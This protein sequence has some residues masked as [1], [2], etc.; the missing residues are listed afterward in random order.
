VTPCDTGTLVARAASIHARR[1][2]VAALVLL[3]AVPVFAQ[4][5][6]PNLEKPDNV[7]PSVLKDIGFDQNLGAQTPMDALF[8]DETGKDVA[9]G[10]LF[11]GKPV[12][13]TLVYYKCPMLCR[14]TMNGVASALSILT[15]DA[16]RDF[17]VVTVSFDPAEGPEEATKKKKETLARYRRP[18]AEGAWHFLTG[19]K[20]SIARLTK[21]VGF[22]YAWDTRT[23]QWAHPAGVVILTPDG[24]VARYM[25]GVEYAPRDLRLALVEASLGKIGTPVDAILLYCYHYDPSKGRYGAAVLNLVRAGG[26]LTVGALAVFIVLMA[27][28]GRGKSA[29]GVA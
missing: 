14:I 17:D 28:R 10:Q 26:I 2:L 1:G 13:L 5:R 11:R 25:Y 7:T 15:L 6:E 16:G 12:V 27:R 29:T 20:E 21:A 18:D 9:L 19:T 3:L 23:E 22:R 4:Y 8:R 24:K